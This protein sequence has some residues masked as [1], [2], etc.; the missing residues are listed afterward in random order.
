MLTGIGIKEHPVSAIRCEAR[1]AHKRLSE[2]IKQHAEAKWN[3]GIRSVP[4][5]LKGIHRHAD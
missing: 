5:D 3:R 4:R 2:K 1:R